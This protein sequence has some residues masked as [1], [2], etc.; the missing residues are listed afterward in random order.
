MGLQSKSAD[1]HITNLVITAVTDESIVVDANHP[2][3]GQAL[4]FD[5]ELVDIK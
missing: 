5:I 1:G 3:A 4:S 2:L